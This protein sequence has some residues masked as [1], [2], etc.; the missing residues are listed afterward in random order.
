MD[1]TPERAGLNPRSPAEADASPGMAPGGGAGR[2]TL[3]DLAAELGLSHATVSRALADH[4]RISPD[5]KARVHALAQRMGYVPNAAAR[6]MRRSHSPLVGLIVPDIQNEFYAS[7]AKR[8]ADAAAAHG[9]QLVLSVTEDHQEREMQEV[10][11]LI[12]A[13]AVAIIITPTAQPD[14]RTLAWLRSVPTV[15]LVRRHEGIAGDAIL[16]DDEGGLEAAT[17][18]LIGYGHRRI[19]YIGVDTD[20]SCGR[21]R[22]QGFLNAMRA[23]GLDA[24]R[25]SLGPPRHDFSRHAVQRYLAGPDGPSAL[26]MGSTSLTVGA[27]LALRDLDRAWPDTISVVGYGDAPWFDLLGPGLTTLG[28]PVDDMGR[29]IA[30][31]LHEGGLLAPPASGMAA[32]ATVQARG[33]RAATPGVAAAAPM[34]FA[35]RLILRGSTR[36]AH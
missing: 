19:A 7:M 15:Q 1:D 36:P 33:A 5:T 10:R 17:R 4:P 3:R 6:N 34:R 21:D 18:H 26:V 35:P 23:E 20:I 14:R 2:L 16:V 32:D 25:V 28:L 9:H 27:L 12:E 29:Y 24:S 31:L 11:A 30:R 8:L 13:R 22:L